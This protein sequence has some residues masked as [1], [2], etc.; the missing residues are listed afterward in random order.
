MARSV[1][2]LV[3]AV[4]YIAGPPALAAAMK[5]MLEQA[6]ADDEEINSEDFSGY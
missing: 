6:G 4:C 3:K 2:S 1:G 5:N